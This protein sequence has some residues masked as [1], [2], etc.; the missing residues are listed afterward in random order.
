MAISVVIPTLNEQD[1][2]SNLLNDLKS[3]T[4]KA[5]EIIVVDGYSDDS[6]QKMVAKFKNIK[7]LKTKRGVGL[8]RTV[9]AKL[10]KYELV[11]FFDA[12]VRLDKNFIKETSGFMNRNNL[13]ISIPIY[14]PYKSTL[15][16]QS[17]YWLFNSLFI[18]FQ[19]ISPSGA[20]SCIIVRSEILKKVNY[21]NS[22]LT[23]EDIE[24]IR[25]SAKISKFSVAPFKL[26]VSD[27]RF[28]KYGPF[29]MLGL[30]LLLSMFFI[31][32]QFK[33]ANSIRYSF[34]NFNSRA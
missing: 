16:I 26:Y 21:F 19:K 34:G 17:I 27:R 22:N 15:V 30:Y 28:K 4:L 13:G 24:F 9:G 3:Q 18:I 14:T 11:Y 25:K 7:F 6:T 20:G 1:Y 5:D 10:A 33:L 12:D 29:K 8:Q 23:Y 2:I 31:T 32:G